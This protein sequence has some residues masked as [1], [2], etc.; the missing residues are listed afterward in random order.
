MTITPV[1]LSS[2]DD[3]IKKTKTILIPELY[4]D[5]DDSFLP[6]CPTDETVREWVCSNKAIFR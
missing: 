3:N 4:I 2:Y 6:G 1:I 5:V